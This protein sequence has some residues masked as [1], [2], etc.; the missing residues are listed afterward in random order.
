MMSGIADEPGVAG[1]L[2]DD[3]YMFPRYPFQLTGAN[4][5]I[6]GKHKCQKI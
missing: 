5:P 4:E 2:F 3:E 1:K 6:V